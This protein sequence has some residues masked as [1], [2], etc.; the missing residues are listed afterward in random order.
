MRA[1]GHG[2]KVVFVQFMK[3][4][5]DIGE[6]KACKKLKGFD[7]YQFGRKEFVDLRIPSDE[8]K[9]LAQKGLGFARDI[10]KKKPD[11]LVLDEINLAV[12]IGL[13]E[14]D[15]VLDLISSAPAKTIIVLTGRKA[16]DSLME[17]CDIVTEIEDLKTIPME[18]RKG[19]IKGFEF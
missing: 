1:W 12:S 6:F 17:A 10:L 5:K 7:F 19:P 16:K 14:E 2:K 9:K 18:K 3:G 15:D 8:D 4:R 13:I 11:M